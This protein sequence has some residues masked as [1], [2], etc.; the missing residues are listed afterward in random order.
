V[1]LNRLEFPFY[2]FLFYSNGLTENR[3]ISLVGGP[4]VISQALRVLHFTLFGPTR[5]ELDEWQ[6]VDAQTTNSRS[7][8]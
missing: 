8:R 4:E 6:T 7:Q 3:K 5:D 1:L 2:F